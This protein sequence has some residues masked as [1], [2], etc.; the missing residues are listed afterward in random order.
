MPDYEKRL[1]EGNVYIYVGTSLPGTRDS[2]NKWRIS[3][4]DEVLGVTRILYAQGSVNFDKV[5]TMRYSYEY[6]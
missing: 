3:R 2:E 5:W 6:I 1:D 4:M